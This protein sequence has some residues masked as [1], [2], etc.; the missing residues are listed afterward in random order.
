MDQHDKWKRFGLFLHGCID[1]FTGKIL[2]LVIWWT[3]SNPKFVCAQYFKAI[4]AV[5]GMS[6]LFVPLIVS[7]SDRELGAPCV[8]QSDLGMENYNVVYAHTHIRHA[9]DPTLAGSIQHNWKRGH[10]NIKPEQMW[11]RF[12]RTWVSGFEGLLEQGVRE[13]WYNNI[14]VADRYVLQ[15]SCGVKNL[16]SVVTGWSSVGWQYPG[17]RR[18]WIHMYI[19]IIP[20]AGG[21]VVARFYPTAS[22]ML[23]SKIQKQ[24]TLVTSR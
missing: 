1:G 22:R 2:W 6:F 21:Q 20:A 15:H 23:C 3:N 5:G 12:R 10:M 9:L 14:N 16:H 7:V 8:T 18:S 17:S 4:R 19:I 24:S 11:W 13:Q